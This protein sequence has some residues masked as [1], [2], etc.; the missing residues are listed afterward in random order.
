MNKVHYSAA[1]R[2]SESDS[3]SASA[4]LRFRL[5]AVSPLVALHKRKS[6]CTTIDTE[7]NR[8][9]EYLCPNL[10]TT[11]DSTSTSVREKTKWRSALAD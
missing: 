10:P 4:F 3:L 7:E 5:T 8:S 11:T 9:V 1:E 2:R 6:L